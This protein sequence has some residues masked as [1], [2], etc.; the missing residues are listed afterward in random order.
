MRTQ[1]Y[2]QHCGTVGVPVVTMRGSTGIT[3]VLFLVMVVPGLIYAIWRASTKTLA[4]PSCTMPNPIPL[5]APKAVAAGAVPVDEQ[6][7]FTE[8]EYL[9]HAQRAPGVM[10]GVIFGIAG[11]LILIGLLSI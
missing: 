9:A 4:C 5:T 8:A 6:P 11:L 1:M 10:A 3:F 7:A 2:C